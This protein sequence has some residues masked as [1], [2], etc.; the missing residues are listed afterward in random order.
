MVGKTACGATV[1][2]K[3]EKL[4]HKALSSVFG[5]VFNTR[6]TSNYWG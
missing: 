6:Q 2:S 4:L 3:A 5:L 1:D